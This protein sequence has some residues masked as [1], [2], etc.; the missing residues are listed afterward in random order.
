M[1]RILTSAAINE[2]RD[3]HM[4]YNPVSLAFERT[5]LLEGAGT[6]LCLQ[7]ENFGTSWTTSGT[8]SRT[9][10]AV[11]DTVMGVSLDLLADADG[12]VA[13]YYQQ[14]IT[15]TADGTKAVSLFMK[16]GANPAASASLIVLRDATA[17]ADR[18]VASVAWDTSGVP[19]VTP[20]VGTLQETP[21]EIHSGIYRIQLIAPSVVAANTNSL[22]VAPVAT[23]AQ[24]GDVYAGGVQAE[25]NAFCT[26]YVK[27]TTATVTRS[28]DSLS[29]P[30]TLPPQEMTVYA[31]F[32]ERGSLS[33]AAQTRVVNISNVAGGAAAPSFS[34]YVSSTGP[35]YG[36][37]HHNGTANV[38]SVSGVTASIGDL[39]EVRA[40]LGAD[41]KVTCGVS[42]NGA[43]ETVGV[44]S[45]AN[46]LAS[47][48]ASQHLFLNTSTGGALHGHNAFQSV[49]V[50][51]GTK[52][53]AEM[54]LL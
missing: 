10:A 33:G 23:A 45:A 54:R 19:T 28:A 21:R 24:T 27:T 31:K 7:S 37:Q 47:A 43:A 12:A 6:N 25:N 22:R 46:A 13:G 42:K 49:K 3:D 11:P 26:S 44:T 41:G 1:A 8:M 35:S 18:L 32:I 15:F 29:F 4:V 14:N 52:T 38:S 39:I 50:A 40:V 17:A 16:R 20:S 53:M 2:A 9:A 30:F 34:I 51:R 48:W 5:L 36:A